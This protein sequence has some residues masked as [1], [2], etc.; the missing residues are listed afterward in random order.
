M[1]TSGIVTAQSMVI[2]ALGIPKGPLPLNSEFVRQ[3]FGSLWLEAGE[4]NEPLLRLT[5]PWK[6]ADEDAIVTDV[7]LEHT[8]V[9]FYWFEIAILL[10]W[11]EE[12]LLNRYVSKFMVVMDRI[13]SNSTQPSAGDMDL[14]RKK[15]FMGDFW[16]AAEVNPAGIAWL[17]LEPGFS[18]WIAS[19][20]AKSASTTNVGQLQNVLVLAQDLFSRGSNADGTLTGAELEERLGDL[21]AGIDRYKAGLKG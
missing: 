16:G 1:D 2:A 15:V 19:M 8:D 14:I 20:L 6:V 3:A 9:L 10:G 12:D 18:D 4:M 5:R 21:K 11:T 13:R 7:S 17:F